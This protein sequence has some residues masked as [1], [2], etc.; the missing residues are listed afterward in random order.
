MRQLEPQWNG[1]LVTA[2]IAIS[3]LGTFTSTQLVCQAR[4]SRHLPAVL[5]WTFLASL[6]FGFCSIWC[7]HF[8]AM[9]AY[10]L[11]LPIGLNVPLTILSAFL[12]VLFTFVALASD[13]VWEVLLKDKRRLYRRQGRR[14]RLDDYLD[15]IG[16]KVQ[17][18][19]STEPLVSP[20]RNSD[21]HSPSHVR[22][23]SPS[24]A[25][26][27]PQRQASCVW[28]DAAPTF[29]RPEHERHG[30]ADMTEDYDDRNGTETSSDYSF[31]RRQSDANSEANSFT[32]GMFH[33]TKT[34]KPGTR[35]GNPL[36]IMLMGLWYG[37]TFLNVAKGFLWSLAITS[38]HYSGIMALRVPEGWCTLDPGLVLLSAAISWVVCSV[39]CILMSQMETFLVQQ[40]LFAV[41]ATTG[42][43]TM[44][45]TGMSAAQFWSN[46]EAR[47]TRGYPTGLSVTIVCIATLTCLAANGLLVHSATVARDKLTE[48][49]RT[50]RKLWAALAQKEH[51]EASAQARSEFIASASHEIRTPLHQ[52]QGYGDLL[53]R[54]KLSEEGRMLLCAIQDATKTLSLIT[55][56]VLD[57]SRLEKGESANR[58]TFL[59]VRNVIDSVI[60]LLPNRNEDNQ[61]E[62][63]VAISP[64]VPASLFM[65]ELSLTRII[66]N[67]LSN[68]CK[69]TTHGYVLL[70]VNMENTNLVIIVEDT[71]CGVPENFLPQ[72]FEPFKQAQTR[73]AERGTGLGL[74]IVKQLLAKMR[75]TI[76]VESYYRD[77]PGVG[78][79]KQ[80]SKFTVTIPL[81]EGPSGTEDHA[82]ADPGTC[83]AVFEDHNLRLLDGLKRAW[84]TFSVD[85]R[86]VSLQQLSQSFKYVWVSPSMLLKRPDILHHLMTQTSSLV[87]IPYDNENSLYEVL[88]V[89]LP[90]HL[91]P[92]RRPLA[93]HRIMKSIESIRDVPFKTEIK[94]PSIR[95]AE[96]IEIIPSTCEQPSNCASS[97][98]MTA[99]PKQ[100]FKIMLVEDNKINQKLGVK[101]LQ[102]FGYDVVVAD[103]GQEALEVLTEQDGE[104]DLILM[105]QSMPRKDGLQATKEIRELEEE[106]RLN[107]SRRFR[108]T[109]GRRHVIIAVTA[110]VGPA[111]EA[112]CKTV[113]ADA[114]LSKPLSLDRLKEVLATWLN[115]CPRQ[116][117]GL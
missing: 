115:E 77:D 113:G 6:T 27:R 73:G 12:A 35:T 72:L 19:E 84:A 44:H 71:G 78:P 108:G 65:D 53:A 49:I 91:I 11:D 111:H 107:G 32:L 94:R 83:V 60:G 42:V 112:L 13:L 17:N 20:S 7:L 10:E 38:M 100:P 36:L 9:L 56:N 40:V 39:G 117:N 41:V 93:W 5:L 99:Q 67:L 98:K 51:A 75:G 110:V 61:V 23:L 88:G 90:Y 21:D 85:V 52:L 8:V 2:S 28:I 101:M 114:F 25:P 82:K 34:W 74:S 116:V 16:S 66:L 58:P 29:L 63:L 45:F 4:L 105:D 80:G 15:S 47:E 33:S 103:D 57:W 30:S 3:L 43:A 68:A 70:T 86:S 46:A 102:K 59:D 37:L 62:I 96:N 22:P 1:G 76:E 24:P 106:G 81:P 79:D 55:N 54:E 14:T 97:E 109:R 104:I 64:D 89:K 48:I 92:L 18:H 26:L 31:L 95:F 87:F 50:R 69:F